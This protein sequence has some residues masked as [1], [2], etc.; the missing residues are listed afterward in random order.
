[1]VMQRQGRKGSADNLAD[2]NP[3]VLAN[4][5]VI[6][7]DAGRK[8]RPSGRRG[9]PPLLTTEKREDIYGSAEELWASRPLWRDAATKFPLQVSVF[10]L[11]ACE[12]GIFAFRGGTSPTFRGNPCPLG[13]G[14]R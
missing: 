11:A 4:L 8:L 14:R 10:G 2:F 5:T 7:A 9:S 6:I 13:R 3:A 12:K 1:M